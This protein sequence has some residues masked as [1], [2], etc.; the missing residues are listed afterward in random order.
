MLYVTCTM[1]SSVDLAHDGL[2]RGKEVWC[3]NKGY[4]NLFSSSVFRSMFVLKANVSLVGCL[5]IGP[6]RQWEGEIIDKRINVQ[7]TLT[8][9]YCKHSRPLNCLL[10]P[11]TRLK[12]DTR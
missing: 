5:G 3:K 11:T 9:T 8:N 10:L 6:L 12:L 7:T 4:I 2:S 1:I